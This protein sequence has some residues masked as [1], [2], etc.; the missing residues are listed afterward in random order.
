[1]KEC[2]WLC[3]RTARH[4]CLFLVSDPASFCA[5]GKRATQIRIIRSLFRDVC[6]PLVV[7]QDFA[8]HMVL[9]GNYQVRLERFKR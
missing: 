4:R 3:R 7:A 5:D 6:C 1:M 9:I 8:Y 2:I